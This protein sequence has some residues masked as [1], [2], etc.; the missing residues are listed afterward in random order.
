MA[1]IQR[2]F[3]IADFKDELPQSIRIE[4]R[5]WAKGFIRLGLDVQRFSYRNIME[6]LSPIRSR[7]V[8][9]RW[10]KPR[11]DEA[12]VEQVRNYHPDLV[13]LLAMKSLDAATVAAVRAAAPDAAVVG[14][15]VDWCPQSNPQRV[16]IARCMDWVIASNAGEYLEYYKQQGV[17]KC[18]FI[19]CPCDPDIQRPYAPEARFQTDIFFS[20]KSDHSAAATDPDRETILSRLAKMPDARVYGAF[21]V[22]RI[23]GIDTYIAMSNAKVSLSIN[24]VNHVRLYHSDRFVASL[25]CGAFTLAKRVPDTELLFEDGKHLRYFDTPEEFFALAE[26]YLHHDQDRRALAAAGMERAHRQFNSTVMAGHVV[27]L[28]EKGTYNAPW[29]HIL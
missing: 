17:P 19:P 14:R 28:V 21:G 16:A 6:Q 9:A 4:R 12:L 3:L 24:A 2:V 7:R 23:E 5:H 29:A 1:K 10:G 15:D 13:L 25:S 8:A 22:G 27:D 20:G 26:H 11:A 18:A